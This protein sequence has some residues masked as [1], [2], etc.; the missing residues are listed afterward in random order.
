MS[1]RDGYR[2][3]VTGLCDRYKRLSGFR[4]RVQQAKLLNDQDDEPKD[5][6]DL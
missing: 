1:V 2:H 4:W 6:D 3:R 5:D